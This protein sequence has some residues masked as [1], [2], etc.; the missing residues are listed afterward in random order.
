M[1]IALD[2]TPTTSKSSV[3]KVMPGCIQRKRGSQG[4][5]PNCDF[6]ISHLQIT[7]PGSE[8]I[9]PDRN[10]ALFKDAFQQIKLK[11]S[12]L[13]VSIRDTF[14][15]CEETQLEVRKVNH[16]HKFPT[17]TSPYPNSKVVR[18][19]RD[20]THCLIMRSFIYSFIPCLFI[21]QC[22]LRIQWMKEIWFQ[23]LENIYFNAQVILNK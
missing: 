21:E 20:L 19:M 17:T 12:A 8:F 16:L 23:P 13:Q 22:T 11:L 6:P 3:P 7:F 10:K 15:K 18:L 2:S 9:Y 1:T 4:S 14:N 5:E